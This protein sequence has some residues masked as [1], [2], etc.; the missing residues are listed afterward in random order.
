MLW[1]LQRSVMDGGWS[2]AYLL[3]LLE[4]P[5]VQLYADRPA[6][7]TA[8][9]RPFSGLVPAPWASTALAYLKEMEVLQSR[10]QDSKGAPKAKANPDVTAPASPKRRPKFPK[11]PKGGVCALR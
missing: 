2:I 1:A 4:E 9:G 11:K 3:S 10:K 6:A 8:L 5:P 7:L